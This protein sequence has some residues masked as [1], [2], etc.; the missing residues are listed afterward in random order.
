MRGPVDWGLY[1]VTDRQFVGSRPLEDLVRA[2]L[3]GGITAV[4]LREKQ[5]STREFVELARRVKTIVASAG[6]PLI[7]NDRVDIALV[8]GADGVH[9][10]QLDMDCRDARRILGPDAIIGLSVENMEQAELAASLDADYLAASPIFATP[11]KPELTGEWG[12]EGLAALRAASRRVLVA[13]GGIYAANAA[14]VVRTGADGI[15][16]VSAICA[17]PNPETAARELRDIVQEARRV[18]R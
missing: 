17:A 4:Q 18:P 8:A 15:A 3:R 12:L 2:A 6:V 16:V 11:T 10:G 5:A 13:I 1:L 14:E 9:L 7:I